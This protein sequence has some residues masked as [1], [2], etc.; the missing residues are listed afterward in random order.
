MVGRSLY[1]DDGLLD[2]WASVGAK[3]NIKSGFLFTNSRKWF[4]ITS[5]VQG[6]VF[7]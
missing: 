5:A 6:V 3:D 2:G 4:E 1:D 7:I